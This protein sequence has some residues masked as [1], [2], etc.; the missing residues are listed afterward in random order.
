MQLAVEFLPYVWTVSVL[1]L[2]HF[3]PSVSYSWWVSPVKQFK[4]VCEVV[5]V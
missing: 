5:T 1:V 3:F 2:L 4:V